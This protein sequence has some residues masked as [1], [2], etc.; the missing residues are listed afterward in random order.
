M[1]SP[2]EGAVH[3]QIFP[4]WDRSELALLFSDIRLEDSLGPLQITTYNSLQGG[5]A[6]HLSSE[7]VSHKK[8]FFREVV[9]ATSAAPTFLRMADIGGEDVDPMLCVD[10]GIFE[11]NPTLASF[12]LAREISGDPSPLVVSL[13]TGHAKH[14]PQGPSQRAQ[15]A[16]CWGVKPLF[17]AMRG[18]SDATHRSFARLSEQGHVRY[19]RIAPELEDP[20]LTMD[21]ARKIPAL[22][23]RAQEMIAT[24]KAL[25]EL[26][27]TIQE[28]QQF[29]LD[30]K[31][32]WE[33]CKVEYENVSL[34]GFIR[35]R[36]KDL[37]EKNLEAPEARFLRVLKKSCQVCYPAL[38]LQ[39]KIEN[40]CEENLFN[41]ELQSRESPAL[42]DDTLQIDDV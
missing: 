29:I 14:P 3:A 37:S 22:K 4:L 16:C 42:E 23:E 2:V 6:Q 41:I 18:T 20:L 7:N 9:V 27:E 21:D 40:Q 8:Y 11:N 19:Y 26:I 39:E 35:R 36:I 34:Q 32:E 38:L 33:Q 28:E 12:A 1:F 10:G 31:Q 30:L 25:Q 17:M 5:G 13:G 15:G 24:H